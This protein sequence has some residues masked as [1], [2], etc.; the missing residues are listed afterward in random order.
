VGIISVWVADGEE[1]VVE[2][3][4]ALGVVVV[5]LP[6]ADTTIRAT[7]LMASVNGRILLMVNPDRW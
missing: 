4:P 3:A 6:Q 2:G 5:L 1:L 7:A